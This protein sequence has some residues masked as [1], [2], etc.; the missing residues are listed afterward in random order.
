MNI[1]FENLIFKDSEIAFL[2]KYGITVSQRGKEG[3]LVYNDLEEQNASGNLEDNKPYL[4]GLKHC[5][6]DMQITSST[7]RFYYNNVEILEL[8]KRISNTDAGDKTWVA[9]VSNENEVE[10]KLKNEI[11]PLTDGLSLCVLVSKGWSLMDSKAEFTARMI[12][13]MDPMER[14]NAVH[15]EKH[16]RKSP[17]ADALAH[18]QKCPAFLGFNLFSNPPNSSPNTDKVNKPSVLPGAT[19][20]GC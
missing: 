11:D 18:L 17:Y 1:H 7:Y 6:S 16:P 4:R 20:N 14:H 19:R 10:N 8:K 2:S 3:T 12:D 5:A 13:D 15:F 9:H